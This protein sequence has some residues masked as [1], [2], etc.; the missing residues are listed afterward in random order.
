MK[1]KI[2]RGV[3]LM[4]DLK[5]WGVVY[6]DGRS[7]ED[8]WVDPADAGIH[9]PKFCKKPSDLTYKDSPYTAELNSGT[10]VYV[11]RTTRVT[12]KGVLNND[13]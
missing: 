13:T 11:E 7:H 6:E 5:G 9:D 4:K 8:G 3:M 2:E 1:E 12:L 10:L